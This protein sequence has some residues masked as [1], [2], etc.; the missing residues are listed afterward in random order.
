MWISPLHPRQECKI[1]KRCHRTYPPLGKKP[2]REVFLGGWSIVSSRMAGH[3][4]RTERC[5]Y[6]QVESVVAFPRHLIITDVQE[7]SRR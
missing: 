2:G 5:G 4:Y 6:R 7:S 3:Q 1:G